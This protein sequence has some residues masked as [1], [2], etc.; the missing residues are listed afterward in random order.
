MCTR[1]DP[2]VDV[3]IVR[4]TFGSPEDPLRRDPTASYM[5]RAIIDA[6]RPYGMLKTFPTV[7]DYSDE[8][9]SRVQDKWPSF[10]L[11]H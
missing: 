4:K 6:C 1:S 2:E 10:R 3:E 11:E 7:A 5:S 9:E 8:L